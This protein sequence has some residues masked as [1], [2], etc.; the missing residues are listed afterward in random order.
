MQGFY[1]A[2]KSLHTIPCVSLLVTS[3]QS[4]I[5]NIKGEVKELHSLDV[6]PAIM[7][8]KGIFDDA[9][10]WKPGQAE[11][12]ASEICKGNAFALEIIA[13]FLKAKRCTIEVWQ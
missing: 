8:L 6:Q 10:A 7:L 3:R 5:T 2:L 13:G 1:N 12:L 4:V 11:Q 9:G